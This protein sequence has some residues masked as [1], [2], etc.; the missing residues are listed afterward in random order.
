MTVTA[1]HIGLAT[2]KGRDLELANQMRLGEW[3]PR[4]WNTRTI[5]REEVC[6]R[7]SVVN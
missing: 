1:M 4:K 7:A 5:G 3:P 6:V 2:V